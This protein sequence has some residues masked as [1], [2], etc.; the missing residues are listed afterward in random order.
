M[1]P[2][3][4][5]FTLVETLITMLILTSGLVSV[6]LVF[7]YSVRTNLNNHQRTAATLLL[8]DKLEQLKAMPFTDPSWSP[9]EYSDHPGKFIRNWRITG[10]SLR[11]LT[12]IVY[13]ERS[14]LTNSPMEMARAVTMCGP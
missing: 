13:A 6:A 9:G 5:G 11:T 8:Q 10:D 14:G 3:R 1:F 12:I 4:R 7:A 2:K